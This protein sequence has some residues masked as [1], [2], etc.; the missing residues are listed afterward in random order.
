[1]L[2][3]L[4]TTAVNSAGQNGLLHG[5][6]AFLVKQLVA[7]VFSSI[8][9]FGFTWIMLVLINR[10]TPV[11]TSEAEENLG[12]DAALHGEAAYQETF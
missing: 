10:I 5:N 3:V 6:S 7:V 12:L 11:R 2:G 8:Y 4:G 9:A 1:L